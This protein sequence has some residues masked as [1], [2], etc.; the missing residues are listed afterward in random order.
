MDIEVLV[1]RGGDRVVASGRLVRNR[2]GDFFQPALPSRLI[3]GLER[4]VAAPWRGAV[5]VAGARFEALTNRFERD[6]DVEGYAAI[7][8][9]WSRDRLRAIRQRLPEDSPYRGPRWDMP[10]C[11]PPAGGWPRLDWAH[12]TWGR[13][14]GNLDFDL[15]DL[16]DSGAAVAVTT[17]RPSQDQ[18][19][20][21]VAAADRDAV[22]AQLRPQLGD[23]LCVIT[24][25]WTKTALN[26]VR[27]HLHERWEQWNLYGLGPAT[28]ED[29]QT[30]ITAQ[31]TRVLPDIA[32]WATS[33][34]SGILTLQPWLCPSE[35][36]P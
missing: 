11:L 32:R 25:R 35:P 19:V 2:D 24:S 13:G 18:A 1:V 4:Q 34:P 36:Q 26:A 23:L 6:V 30:C 14:V 22:E 17:F 10:P 16:E 29:G 21:V 12:G 27:A 28:G 33:L 8:G 15:G 3:A 9:I 7:T 31:L 5:R 20:L